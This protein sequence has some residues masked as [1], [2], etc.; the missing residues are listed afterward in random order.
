MNTEEFLPHDDGAWVALIR[1]F[2]A[3]HIVPARVG[4]DRMV[5]FGAVGRILTVNGGDR[6][7]VTTYNIAFHAGWVAVRIPHAALRPARMLEKLAL[8]ADG[9]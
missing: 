3:P 7:E 6:S 9:C 8:C 2:K 5:P 1:D 4:Q